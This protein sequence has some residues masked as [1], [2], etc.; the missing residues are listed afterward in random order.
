MIRRAV[1]GGRGRKL[2]LIALGVTSQH[3]RRAIRTPH[4][5]AGLI[6]DHREG[7][8]HARHR[9]GVEGPAIR[10]RALARWARSVSIVASKVSK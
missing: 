9:E 1:P 7:L 3:G 8:D 10:R 4:E 2:A 5:V 6:P